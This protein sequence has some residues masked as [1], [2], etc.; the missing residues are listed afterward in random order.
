MIVHL[1]DNIGVVSCDCSS[2]EPDHRQTIA[3]QAISS[4]SCLL[5]FY[6]WIHWIF[7]LLVYI[8]NT[9]AH[10]YVFSHTC[11]FVIIHLMLWSLAVTLSFSTTERNALQTNTTQY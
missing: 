9:R 10:Y 2:R 11:S 1:G 8:Y 3:M 5:S 6:S 4:L 7:H